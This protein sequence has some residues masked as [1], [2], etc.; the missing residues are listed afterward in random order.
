MVDTDLKATIHEK[1]ENGELGPAD[2]P[3]YLRLFC[4]IGSA[5]DDIQ[6]EVSGWNRRIQFKLDGPEN[7]WIAVDAGKFTDGAGELENPDLIL[8]ISAVN[9]ARMFAGEKDAKAAYMTGALKIDG[10]IP[11]ALKL[12]TVLGIVNEEI[13]Y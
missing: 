12:Q 5:T 1:I 2:I 6:D 9:A 4:Q 3:A 7:V 10:K 13:E 8:T 11:D